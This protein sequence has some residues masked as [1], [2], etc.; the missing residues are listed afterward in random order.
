MVVLVLMA[1]LAAVLVPAMRGTFQ[2]ELLRS[3]ARD[4]AGAMK[5][6]YSQ[7]VTERTTHRVVL[8]LSAK[9]YRL[10]KEASEDESGYVLARPVTGAN[11][12]LDARIRFEIRDQ[13]AF[14][15]EEEQAEPLRP[16]PQQQ[17]GQPDTIEFF[18]DGTAEP[19]EVLLRD[20]A[21]HGLALR[22]NPATA[23]VTVVELGRTQ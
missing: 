6:A 20:Q 10:E 15:D 16:A 11:G 17:A 4:V 7:A 19:K 14:Q 3:A 9:Q 2:D 13:P 1:V 21:G 18:S 8:D 23:H 5:A 22:V 12:A